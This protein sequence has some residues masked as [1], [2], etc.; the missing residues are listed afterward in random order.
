MKQTPWG[1]LAVND[2]HI[3]FFSHAFYSGLMRQ[4]KLDSLESLGALLGWEMPGS[5]SLTLAGRWITEMDAQ[6]VDQRS[7]R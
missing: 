3:H 4:K 6:G 2:A 1:D 5:D 7:R